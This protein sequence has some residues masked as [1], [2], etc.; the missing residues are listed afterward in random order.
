MAYLCSSY[1]DV[2]TKSKMAF[3]SDP[4]VEID[5]GEPTLESDTTGTVDVTAWYKG[6]TMSAV[7]E[8]EV[9]DNEWKI[10]DINKK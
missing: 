8:L 3:G 5:H 4:R 7:Y 9:E 6:E 2:M 1:K 10:C